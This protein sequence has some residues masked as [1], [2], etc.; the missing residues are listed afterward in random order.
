MQKKTAIQRAPIGAVGSGEWYPI[1]G[2]VPGTH[3]GLER[4]G[5]P[6]AALG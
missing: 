1:G 6:T 3:S 2:A 5:R 4:L